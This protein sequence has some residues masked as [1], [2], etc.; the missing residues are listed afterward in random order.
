MKKGISLIVLVITIIVMI[1]LAASVVI[2]LSNT[3]V[4]NRASQA[5]D[6]T[7]E[8]QV[9]D[10]A[11]LVWADAYMDN[12]R[13]QDLIDEVTNKLEQQGIKEDKWNMNISNTGIEVTV[14]V[15]LPTAPTNVS[16]I[17][18][19]TDTVK[20]Q[21]VGGTIENGEIAGYQY[22]MD[23]TNWS[24]TISEGVSYTTPALTTG[25]QWIV[26]VRTVSVDGK[27]SDPIEYGIIR[28]SISSTK[29][30]AKSGMN[31]YEWANSIYNNSN[32]WVCK[33]LN[34]EVTDGG[35]FSSGYRW[36]Y[37]KSNDDIRGNVP[38]E[39]TSYNIGIALPAVPIG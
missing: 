15:I 32:R 8:A 21:A 17:E 14:K 20:V 28:F 37:K 38:I 13:G 34:Y 25:S 9:Q 10:F 26:Y 7:N 11:A 12:K 29:F 33:N 31:W 30:Y 35:T 36:I 1:I 2:T 22:S 3:G 19:G 18:V 27:Y 24:E 5:V 39:T 23:G 16:A 4:I 6:A